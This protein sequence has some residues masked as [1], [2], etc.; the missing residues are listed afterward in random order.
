ML[1]ILIPA[2]NYNVL[3]LVKE[4]YEQCKNCSITFE[5]IVV[6]DSIEG[7]KSQENKK[8]VA[9]DN[10]KFIQNETN[11][12]RTLTRKKLADEAKYEMLL[13]L[14]ADV[15][16]VT[17]HFIAGYL[18]YLNKKLVVLGGIAYKNETAGPN[19]ILRLAYGKE[20]EE[21][22]AEIRNKKPYASVL[23]ANLLIPK[24]IF[25]QNNYSENRNLYGMDI[26]F[27]YKLFLNN[28]KVLHIDNAVYHIGLENDTVFFKKSLEAVKSRKDLLSEADGIEN[29]NN[30]L[31]HYKMLKKYN[32][33]E[34]TGF[35]FKI[36]EPFL[37]KMILKKQPNLFCL[38]IYRLGYICTL[39]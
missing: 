13:F 35:V 3:P 12:G 24:D 38:D 6:D 17:K 26:Y 9:F 4:L 31:K 5:I 11:L 23:S 37:K 29:V 33:T 32:L 20:R 8:I 39:K 36:A 18:P 27:S 34:L 22:S 30:L 7:E 28:V 16:P 10:C 19:K 14:D 2:Y 25:L 15:L 21:K 1:S